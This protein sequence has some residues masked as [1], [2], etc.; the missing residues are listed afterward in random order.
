SSMGGSVGMRWASQDPRIVGV[1]ACSPYENALLATKEFIDWKL[2]LPL[3]SPFKLHRG[4]AR[5]LNQVDLPHAVAQ[6]DDMRL[7]ILAG[8]ND[9][10]PPTEQR[11]IFDA[12][13][14]P[15]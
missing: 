11:Q 2:H 9:C 7:Y 4:F 5:M 14:S 1:F 15:R 13:Q 10:F 12:S 8:E 3:P 6:R